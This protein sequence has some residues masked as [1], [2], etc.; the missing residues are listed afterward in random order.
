M[1]LVTRDRDLLRVIE[2][3]CVLRRKPKG[4]VAA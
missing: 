3:D 4:R 1:F 2:L